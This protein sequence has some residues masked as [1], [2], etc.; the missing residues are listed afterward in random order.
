MQLFFSYV[1]LFFR[2]ISI[3]MSTK[4]EVFLSAF[5]FY[6]YPFNGKSLDRRWLNVM[7]G[8]RSVQGIRG[9][10]LYSPKISF[11]VNSGGFFLFFIYRVKNSSFFLS[12]RFHVFNI[13]A[14]ITLVRL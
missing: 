5:N 2:S 7:L 9:F 11:P 3:D 13:H 1:F 14:K 8:K 10:L 12:E 4:V 6:V